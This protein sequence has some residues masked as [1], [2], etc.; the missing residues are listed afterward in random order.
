MDR[1]TYS[2][3]KSVSYM[4]F[5]V[6]DTLMYERLWHVFSAPRFIKRFQY[7]CV[8]FPAGSRMLPR[9]CSSPA[10]AVVHD[11]VSHLIKQNK[12]GWFRFQ[13]KAGLRRATKIIATSQYVRKDLIGLGIDG[14]KIEVVYNGI[15]HELFFPCAVDDSGVIDIKPFAI[16]RPYFIY[17][18]SIQGPEKKHVE[19]IEAFD[20]FKLNTGLPHR[21]VFAGAGGAGLPDVQKAIASSHFA[22]DIF[23]TGHFPHDSLP[24]LYAASDAC[25]FPASSEGSALPVIE[26]M[27]TGIPCACAKSGV[28]P[29]IAGN[30]ALYFNAEDTVSIAASLEKIVSDKELRDT[31]VAGGVEW[32]KRFSWEKTAQR[33]LDVVRSAVG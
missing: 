16:K 2:T 6:P 14:A 33:T 9:A 15:N 3:E 4:G 1:Y 11:V 12:S 7:D 23:L 21:L 10:V 17:A 13:I 19:L 22:S 8:L 18:S 29:E 20:L 26:A 5:S 30:H 31:L 32:T 27:A 28:L 24:L 25:V